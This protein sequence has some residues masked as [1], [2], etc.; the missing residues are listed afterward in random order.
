[1]GDIREERPAELVICGQERVE[2][3]MELLIE[4]RPGYAGCGGDVGHRRRCVAVLTD[5]IED[6]VQ[7]TLAL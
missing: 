7:E 1:V 4:G 5:D 3:V 6:R 2:L